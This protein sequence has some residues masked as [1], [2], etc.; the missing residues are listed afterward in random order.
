[1][2][3]AQVT[4]VDGVQVGQTDAAV[5]DGV[6]FVIEEAGTQF[7]EGTDTTVGGGTSTDG[8]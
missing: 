3:G 8:Q 5:P 2:V 4:E 1:M 6:P 7:G